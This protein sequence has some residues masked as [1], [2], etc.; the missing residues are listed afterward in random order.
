MIA[1]LF[2]TGIRAE[3]R[4]GVHGWE[5]EKPQPF[6]VD[7]DLDV[8]VDQDSIGGTADYRA[9]TETVRGVIESNSFDLLESL[10][11]EVARSVAGLEHVRRATAVVHKPMAAE[12]VG[13]D[14]IAAAASAGD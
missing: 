12:S 8:D 14:G 9:V 4:H 6:V 5:K 10:A 2:L 13:I 7:L 11:A 3:G 1:K